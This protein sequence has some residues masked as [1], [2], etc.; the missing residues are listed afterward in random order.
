MLRTSE[1][2]TYDKRFKVFTSLLPVG[3]I[4]TN[5]SLQYRYPPLLWFIL[6]LGWQFVIKT[7]I[8]SIIDRVHW[9]DFRIN[10]C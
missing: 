10:P 7:I 9:G 8:K 5:T 4:V 1:N 2:F 3:I 6:H